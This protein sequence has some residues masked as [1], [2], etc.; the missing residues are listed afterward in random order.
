MHYCR[1]NVPCACYFFTVNLADRS[2]SLLVDHF[3]ELRLAFK[4]S[5]KII[6]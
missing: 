2:Q 6:G 5:D 4:K 3:D 1:A